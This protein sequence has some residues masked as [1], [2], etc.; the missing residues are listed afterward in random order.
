MLL[1]VTTAPKQIS[2]GTPLTPGVCVLVKDKISA[3]LVRICYKLFLKLLLTNI[4]FSSSLYHSVF[5][6]YR[7]LKGYIFE[8][9]YFV[10]SKQPL[11][12]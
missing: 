2:F 3:M 9:Y 1:S 8:R 5:E 6:A 7:E 10:F 4:S 12:S 11:K